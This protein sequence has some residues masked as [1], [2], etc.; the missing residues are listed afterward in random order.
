MNVACA[1][2]LLSDI[3]ICDGLITRRE[4]PTECGVSERDREASIVRRSWPKTRDCRA[5]GGGSGK[6]QWSWLN[7]HIVPVFTWNNCRRPCRASVR[8][9]SLR[10]GISRGLRT[11]DA[12]TGIWVNKDRSISRVINRY[13]RIP[14]QHTAMFESDT[15][16]YI[17]CVNRWSLACRATSNG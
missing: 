8:I 2:G 15:L 16:D 9:H 1:C 5:M 11:S 6:G 10:P 12:T 17:T 14:H 3:G 7:L 13:T 4:K